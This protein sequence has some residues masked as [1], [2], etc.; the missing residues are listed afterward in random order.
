MGIPCSARPGAARRRICLRLAP[1][2]V[3]LLVLTA[4]GSAPSSTATPAP[5]SLPTSPPPTP[6]RTPTTPSTRPATVSASG[7]QVSAQ[8]QDT[9]VRLSWGPAPNAAGYSVYRD[10][11]E[12]AL[13]SKPIPGT[14][15]EDI[16]LTN[17]RTY[18]YVVSAVDKDGKVIQ[19]TAEVKATPKSS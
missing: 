3:A 16:G 18:S 10:G 2:V 5:T 13:N 4:C 12:A 17:G 14:V 9:V 15:Y 8:A 11:S 19:R 1:V 7:F 6:T